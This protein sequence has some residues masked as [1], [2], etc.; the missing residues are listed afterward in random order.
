MTIE[1]VPIDSVFLDPANV[2]LHNPRNLEA[3]RG[4][5][6]RFKQQRPIVVNA[7]NVV[8]AGNGTLRAARDLGWTTIQITRTSLAGVDAT[9]FA[10]AD[11]RTGETSEWD[12]EALVETLTA[13]RAQDYDI[14]SA[15][16]SPEEFAK[17]VRHDAG[18][19]EPTPPEDFA[20]FDETI[21]VEHECPKCKY[22]WS[23]KSSPAEAA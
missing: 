12:Q 4:S 18:Q 20:E 16:F 9:A 2:R 6:A 13:L 7:D 21:G 14:G 17:M 8:I 15:G 11:N 23:G 5:L 10:I 3:I 1:T 19:D 22:R